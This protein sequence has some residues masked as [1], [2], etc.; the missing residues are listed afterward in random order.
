M[1][2]MWPSM[3]WLL[4]LI[5]A[6]VVVYRSLLQRRRKAALRF[7]AVGLVKQAMRGAGVRRHVPPLLMLAAL[8]ALLV[9]AARP[10]AVV[11]LP[12]Q[13]GTVILAMD[14]SGSMRAEDIPP[15][16]ISVSQDAAKTF[17]DNQ[18]RNVRIGVVAFAGGA[19]VVQAP[20][21][22]RSQVLA[23]IDRFSLQRGTAVGAGILVSLQTIFDDLEIPLSGGLDAGAGRPFG[24]P[25]A[26]AQIDPVAPGSYRSAAIVLLTDGQ[27][28]TGPDPIEA[29]NLA[30][31][32]GVRVYTVG[33]GTP[34]GAVVGFTGWTRRVQLDQVTLQAIAR[35]TNAEYFLAT[36]T[37]L[38][39]IYESL[40]S[41]L[42]LEV[43]ETEITA[44]FSLAGAMLMLLAGLL[45]VAWFAKIA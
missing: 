44:G 17:I 33:L 30:A 35:A 19:G 12:S 2:F 9:A 5:P 45:S 28:T 13:R 10:T 21:L 38:R 1:R 7:A 6:L 39:K 43:E 36:S 42:V 8:S 26:A 11:T 24:Q 4:V 14:I 31:D 16:R 20:T 32:L 23:A 15:N 41:D 3:L 37:D 40:S 22:N 25:S 34:G 29:A 18:P 27:N